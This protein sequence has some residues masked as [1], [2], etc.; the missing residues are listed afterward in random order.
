M[1]VRACV[2]AHAHACACARVCTSRTENNE[3]DT[4]D[5]VS[6]CLTNRCSDPCFRT[7]CFAEWA[8]LACGWHTNSTITLT[9]T[10]NLP[11]VR[12]SSR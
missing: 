7:Y 5:A 1:H 3:C 9:G 11:P 6:S 4:S 12:T 8:L 10:R 2:R